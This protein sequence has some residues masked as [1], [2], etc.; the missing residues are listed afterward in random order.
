[1]LGLWPSERPFRP[2]TG[3]RPPFSGVGLLALSCARSLAVPGPH[4]VVPVGL[5]LA[6]PAR[7]ARRRFAAPDRCRSGRRFLLR[8]GRRSCLFR[9]EEVPLATGAARRSRRVLR[10]VLHA[11]PFHGSDR[12][13][14]VHREGDPVAQTPQSPRGTLSMHEPHLTLLPKPAFPCFPCRGW[15]ATAAGSLAQ[16]EAAAA[17]S[18]RSAPRRAEG[19]RES[20][21]A[22]QVEL[23]GF[24]ARARL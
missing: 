11:D 10:V 17:R 18:M 9:G 7:S 15:D 3:R 19:R 5:G 4:R 8:R 12:A 21:P 6:W 14:R 24:G 1:M 23:P 2:P 13:C 22:S 20:T 16:Q